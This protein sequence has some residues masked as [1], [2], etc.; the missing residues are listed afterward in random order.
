MTDFATDLLWEEQKDP[1]L[2]VPDHPWERRQD[3]HRTVHGA[4]PAA[5][6][7]T[8]RLRRVAG[9]AAL[10]RQAEEAENTHKHLAQV[11]HQTKTATPAATAKVPAERKAVQKQV[12][13]NAVAA[14]ASRRQEDAKAAAVRAVALD[15][16]LSSFARD[17]AKADL[18]TLAWLVEKAPGIAQATARTLVHAV[19]RADPAHRA[20]I[21]ARIRTQLADQRNLL[22]ARLLTDQLAGLAPRP[23]RAA[24]PPPAP[25]PPAPSP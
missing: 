5:E 22:L 4:S 14:E 8:D 2:P 7:L 9:N 21:L 11:A 16:V 10:V 15:Q 1:A 13:Q 23:S 6:S 12:A 20:A 18:L 3:R 19:T 17:P 24:L 25:P